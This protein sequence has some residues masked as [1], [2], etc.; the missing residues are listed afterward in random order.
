MMRVWTWYFREQKHRTETQNR[1]TNQETM[2]WRTRK[3]EK[4]KKTK[5][6]KPPTTRKPFSIH[7]QKLDDPKHK[8]ENMWRTKRKETKRKKVENEQ[9]SKN[10]QTNKQHISHPHTHKQC[11]TMNV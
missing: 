4:R 5:G 9:M 8:K 3:V 10:K 6:T 2:V 1:K 7:K 11:K